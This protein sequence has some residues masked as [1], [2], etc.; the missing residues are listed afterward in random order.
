MKIQLKPIKKQ[1]KKVYLDDLED[2]EKEW[3]PSKEI[4]KEWEDYFDSIFGKASCEVSERRTNVN[5]KKT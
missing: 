4:I 3:I 1:K 5:N 2:K